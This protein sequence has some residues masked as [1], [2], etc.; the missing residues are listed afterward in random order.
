MQK[1]QASPAAS[2][3]RI[4][5]KR[6]SSQAPAM[7]EDTAAG[8]TR[9]ESNQQ[10]C[11]VPLE[12][13][14]VGEVK[15]RATVLFQA[16]GPPSLS[17]VE[18]SSGARLL[19]NESF[20]TATHRKLSKFSLARKAPPTVQTCHLGKESPE[21]FAGSE[22]A[23][24]PIPSSD[25]VDETIGQESART[26]AAMSTQEI[27]EAQR[28]LLQRLPPKTVEF[29]RRRRQMRAAVGGQPLPSL[30]APGAPVVEKESSKGLQ[31]IDAQRAS[32]SKSSN[33]VK[34]MNS[35]RRRGGDAS[36]TI[37]ARLRFGMDGRVA[38]LAPESTESA[39]G[40]RHGLAAASVVSR[41]PIRAAE[42]T[43]P[44]DGYT[45]TEAITLARSSV[46][47]Q[48]VFALRLLASILRTAKTSMHEKCSTSDALSASCN[49][50]ILAEVSWTFVWQ[51]AV[52]EADIAV[53]LRTG[54]DDGNA[55]VVIAASEALEALL[56]FDPRL[57][58]VLEVAD[59][60]PVVGWPAVSVRHLQRPTVSV[61]WVA[62]P[63][64]LVQRRE[65]K[66]SKP[67]PPPPQMVLPGGGDSDDEEDD[68]DEKA[69]AKVDPMCGLINM[70]LCE[71]ISYILE[72]FP[73]AQR[74][75]AGAPLLSIVLIRF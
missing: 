56:S 33:W 74:V 16:L 53:A 42:G 10:P 28:E 59:A 5:P 31:S 36:E 12:N 26:L 51:H 32:A 19:P 6:A 62:A 63:L 8:S 21:F 54:L 52:Q 57:R 67:L 29:L 15:E 39:V 41:D 23:A 18:S 75:A 43:V 37:A 35:T 24:V 30:E 46:P 48:R 73:R 2:V 25:L 64:N 69:L 3:T 22:A 40:D 55:A 34:V 70:N 20:P 14:V 44:T 27:E 38:G 49:G 68:V 45:I 61:P 71:R 17:R 65:R 66:R 9:A 7:E 72:T 58:I 13:A 60:H 4:N 1:L 50:S 11:G 47:Q